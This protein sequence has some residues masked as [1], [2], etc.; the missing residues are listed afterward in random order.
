MCNG[1]SG[2]GFPHSIASDFLSRLEDHGKTTVDE[3]L[4]RDVTGVMFGG[5]LL[6]NPRTI[7]RVSHR[8]L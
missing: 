6:S 8:A 5:K 7:V 4:I 2:E 3:E 1:Q